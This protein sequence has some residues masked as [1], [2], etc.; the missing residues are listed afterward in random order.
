VPLAIFDIDGT[1][2]DTTAVDA[3]CY[4]AAVRSVLGLGLPEDW[5]D[6]EDVTDPLILATACQRVGRVV[7]DDAAQEKIAAHVAAVLESALDREPE[8]FRPIPGAPEI[9]AVLAD[10]GWRVAIATGAWR[11]SALV[12]LRAGGI[13][14][15]G[16]PLATATEQARRVDIVRGAAVLADAAG[17]PVVYFG[18]GVWDLRAARALDYG[19]VG[20]GRGA[21]AARLVEAG[22]E[23]V[24]ADFM[25][26]AALGEYLDRST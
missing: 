17:P 25:D 7:P 22:A 3:E 24:V 4:D 10:A 20:V 16:V 13:P 11:P 9:F 19:F 26:T 6:L 15:E 23:I 1:L 12:K 18:D 5:E 2:T 14:Y 21:R 8:R